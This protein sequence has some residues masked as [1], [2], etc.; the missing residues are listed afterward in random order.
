MGTQFIQSEN[1]APYPLKVAYI[2][3][4]INTNLIGKIGPPKIPISI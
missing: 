3:K 4:G 2:N 1:A